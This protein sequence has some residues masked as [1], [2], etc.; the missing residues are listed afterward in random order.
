M[1]IA[2]SDGLCVGYPWPLLRTNC[3]SAGERVARESLPPEDP[4]AI[5]GKVPSSELTEVRLVGNYAI[6]LTWADGHNVGIYTWQLLRE[7][8]DD[9]SIVECG[10][11]N[12]D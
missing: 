6:G 5:L 7:L 11:R 9:D 12:A 3:P 4:L 8:A 1:V 2:W 10:M